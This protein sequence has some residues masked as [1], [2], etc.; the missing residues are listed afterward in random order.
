MISNVLCVYYVEPWTQ[1]ETLE[2]H[3]HFAKRI[4]RVLATFRFIAVLL[5]NSIQSYASSVKLAC[6][7]GCENSISPH[8]DVQPMMPLSLPLTCR[9]GWL[10]PSAFDY[11]HNH[12]NYCYR[13]AYLV[14]R[15]HVRIFE[16]YISAKT[17]NLSVEI[18]LM[19]ASQ[20]GRPYVQDFY[21]MYT[22]CWCGIRLVQS[23]ARK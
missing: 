10:R 17:L 11:T 12:I 16:S 2:K 15:S 21:D 18:R 22:T 20:Y 19:C 13:F 6:V 7:G 9:L 14:G 3:T 8:D 4:R 5:Y 23:R 1:T